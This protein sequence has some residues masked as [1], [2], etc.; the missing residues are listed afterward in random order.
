MAVE[1]VQGE[2]SSDFNSI[3]YTSTGIQGG[4]VKINE[5]PALEFPRVDKTEKFDVPDLVFPPI[6]DDDINLPM[7]KSNL[8]E[9][10]N[11][12]DKV[13]GFFSKLFGKVK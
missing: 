3:E 5:V 9:E 6:V 2:L 4:G 13:S 11:N 10:E 12:S 8:V 1:A 7:P